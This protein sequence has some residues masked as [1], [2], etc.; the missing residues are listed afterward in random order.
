[1]NFTQYIATIYSVKQMCATVVLKLSI[2]LFIGIKHITQIKRYAKRRHWIC[3]KLLGQTINSLFGIFPMMTYKHATPVL[4][5]VFFI[6][7]TII[8]AQSCIMLRNTVM[9]TW[10][11]FRIRK[12]ETYRKVIGKHIWQW[13]NAAQV[14]KPLIDIVNTRHNSIEAH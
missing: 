2:K 14:I 9:L 11:E 4:S 8:N 12:E 13:E 7:C 6:C 10:V 3:N 1:V 5:I